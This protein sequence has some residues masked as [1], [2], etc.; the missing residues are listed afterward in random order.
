[1]KPAPG[2]QIVEKAVLIFQPRNARAQPFFEIR[3]SAGKV[4]Q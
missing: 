4:G 1:M 3:V 2:Y